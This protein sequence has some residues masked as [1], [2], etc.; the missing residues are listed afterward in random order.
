MAAA[1]AQSSFAQLAE[2]N[3]QGCH[4]AY[5]IRINGSAFQPGGTGSAIGWNCCL[6]SSGVVTCE[7]A[8]QASGA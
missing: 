1:A 8:I 6:M 4:T 5:A 2:E 3:P 7:L